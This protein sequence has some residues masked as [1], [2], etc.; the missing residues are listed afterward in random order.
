LSKI[1][2]LDTNNLSAQITENYLLQS[3][4]DKYSEQVLKRG[5]RT[6]GEVAHYVRCIPLV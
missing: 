4:D 6:F 5:I 2:S 1:A 3:L